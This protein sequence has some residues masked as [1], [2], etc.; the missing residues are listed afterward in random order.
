VWKIGFIFKILQ[1]YFYPLQHTLSPPH[2]YTAALFKSVLQVISWHPV[3]QACHFQFH[4]ID[5]LKWVP[6][7]KHFS[8]WGTGKSHRRLNPVNRGG[9]RALECTYRLKIASP[10]GH[11]ELVHRL[12]AETVISSSTGPTFSYSLVL[13]AW[14]GPPCSTFD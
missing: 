7:S 11:C 6:F 1:I 14:S 12:V 3:W 4:L 2:L 9:V 8:L 10:R 5:M 13:G